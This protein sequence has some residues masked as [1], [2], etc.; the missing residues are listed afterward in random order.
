MYT[1]D[2]TTI[3]SHTGFAITKGSWEGAQWTLMGWPLPAYQF[4]YDVEEMLLEK[5]GKVD[6]METDSEFCMLCIYFKNKAS[7]VSYLKKVEK[8]LDTVKKMV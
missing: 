5:V 6:G 3:N 7:A 8:Y 1:V 2:K 4:A